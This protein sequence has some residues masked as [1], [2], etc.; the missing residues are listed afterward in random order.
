MPT[1][2]LPVASTITSM[3]SETA[4]DASAVNVVAAMR[5]SSQPTVLQASLARC[6]SRSTITGTS[7]PGTCG[8][9]DRNIEPNLPAL[10]SA[11]RSGLS[12]LWRAWRRRKR[13]MGAQISW[14]ERLAH[15]YGVDVH[16][17][18]AG[19]GRREA[20]GEERFPIERL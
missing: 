8:T 11:T 19:R 10:I 4:F 3:G 1:A 12:A 15:G 6:G 20:P 18:P 2:G 9:C 5:A 14:R 13:F 7:S 17:S 16:L